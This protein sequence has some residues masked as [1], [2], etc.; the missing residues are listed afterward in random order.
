MASQLGSAIT[1]TGHQAYSDLLGTEMQNK[2]MAQ[3]AFQNQQNQALAQQQMGMQADQFERGMAD[4]QAQRQ[5]ELLQND[6][7]YQRALKLTEQEQQFR[8]SQDEALRKW[9]EGQTAKVQKFQLE[10]EQLDALR[11]DAREKG[12]QARAESITAQMLEM[13][14]QSARTAMSLT[15]ATQLPGKTERERQSLLT[16]LSQ[17]IGQKANVERQNLKMASD[18]TPGLIG[19]FDEKNRAASVEKFNQFMAGQTGAASVFGP[20]FAD[21]QA[22]VNTG[23]TPGMEWMDLVN[24]ST[25]LAGLGFQ[26][27][28]QGGA[29]GGPGQS[30]AAMTDVL[31]GRVLESALEYL[32]K[33]G[34]K[35][36]NLDATRALLQKALAGGASK[37]EIAQ[38]AQAANVPVTTLKYLFQSA[39]DAYNPSQTN[40]RWMDLNNRYVAAL[41]KA[42]G[43]TNDLRVQATLKAMDAFKS[44]NRILHGV[45]S[46]FDA[47]GVEDL[48]EA[49]KFLDE[50][51]KTGQISPLA[52]SR[53]GSLGYGSDVERLIQYGQ[54]IPEQME[55]AK[56]A[57]VEQGNLAEDEASMRALASLMMRGAAL[58]GNDAYLKRLAD[59]IGERQ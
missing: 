27:T 35:G 3:Q 23:A 53:F 30:S 22:E 44:Q 28:T 48:D 19:T 41:D 25:P 11:Q 47:T 33:M 24:V 14:K 20:N 36:V 17:Q 40:S 38:M 29:I 43:Q 55:R 21:I 5:H 49:V 46:L 1:P 58:G 13:R 2:A 39:A 56:L 45:A 32:P 18:F 37:A 50:A 57:A 6:L 4:V 8:V 26:T 52:T 31:K 34:M 54:Q 59:M 16:R 12:E 42:G 15:L 9:T 7:Q 51:G 10:M